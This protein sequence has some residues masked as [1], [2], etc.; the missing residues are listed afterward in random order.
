MHFVKEK[1][2]IDVNEAFFFFKKAKQN[3]N[4]RGREDW[5]VEMPY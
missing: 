4:P 1:Y 2:F 3:P 5:G